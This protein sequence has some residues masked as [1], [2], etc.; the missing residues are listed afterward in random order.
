MSSETRRLGPILGRVSTSFEI[1]I[2]ERNIDEI[3]SRCM[4]EHFRFN[5]PQL[6]EKSIRLRGMQ[7]FMGRSWKYAKILG[8][9]A[10][11]PGILSVINHVVS[12]DRE[13]SATSL[14][15]R[16]RNINPAALTPRCRA[17]GLKKATD[18]VYQTHP[19]PLGNSLAPCTDD[20][21]CRWRRSFCHYS[22]CACCENRSL[23][24][25]REIQRDS[26]MTPWKLS[27]F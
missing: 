1:L 26:E 6:S 18:K 10:T 15:H 7:S 9:Y 13:T 11:F 19:S 17:F 8:I 12:R 24:T 16:R 5:G 25:F 4:L 23:I 14:Q 27:H 21:S 22:Q 2:D 20:V 3:I